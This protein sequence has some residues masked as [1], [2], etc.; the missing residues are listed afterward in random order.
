MHSEKPCEQVAPVVNWKCIYFTLLLSTGYWYLPP[1][2]KW[3][4]LAMLYFPYIALAYYDHW[5]R[6]QRN[7]GPTYLALFYHWAKPQDSEQI[8]V[9]KNWCPKIK[10]KVLAIDC[11]ILV[12]VALLFP[13]F[14][15]WN[16][17]N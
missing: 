6:C 5:Y 16:K 14:L 4:L 15:R 12:I 1:R 11:L 7:M 8:K 13:F 2:N 17:K 9:Y 3:I 10:N